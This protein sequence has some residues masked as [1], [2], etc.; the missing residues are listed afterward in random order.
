MLFFMTDRRHFLKHTLLTSAGLLVLPLLSFEEEGK[1]AGEDD[2]LEKGFSSPP[3]S[4]RPLAFWMWMNGH[5]TKE[6]IT[7]DLATMK[8]MGLAGAFV[9]NTGMGIPKGPVAYGS[10]RWLA[11]LLHAMNTARGLG[12]DLYLHNSPGYSSTGG[13]RVTPEISMQQ[14]VWTELLVESRG[15][16]DVNLPQPY[17]K[18]DY[19]KDS[20]LLAFPATA[21]KMRMQDALESVW[22]NGRAIDKNR[23][24]LKS[25]S[26]GVELQPDSRGQ[27]VLQLAFAE[28]FEARAISITRKPRPSA[29]LYEDAYDHPPGIVLQ[30]SSDGLRFETVCAVSMP[31]LRFL[32][33]PGTKTFPPVKAKFF[34][35]VTAQPTMLTGVEL[36]AAPRLNDWAGKANFTDRQTAGNE[37]VVE[38][39]FIIDP[40]TVVDLS[41]QLPANGR[42]SC[43]LPAGR[44]TLLRIGHT[45]T[46]TETIASPEG[47]GG[48]E[49]DKFSRQAVDAYFQLY[50]DRFWQRLK[51]FAANSFKGFLIDSY[52]I[53]RQNWTANFPADFEEITGYPILAWMPA[54]TGRIVQSVN[55]SE[56]FLWDVRSTQA[57]LVAE[58]YYGRFK[59]HCAARGLQFYAQPNGDGVFDS[60]QAGQQLDVPMAEFWAR[61]VPGTL[62]LCKQAVSIAHGYGKKT[63]AAEAFTAMPKLSKW[64]GYPVAFKSQADY[65]Y[66]LGINRL[67]FH[68]M[69]HQPYTTGF[70]GM[71][72]G[73]YGT[74]FDRNNTWTGQ[75][76][77]WVDCLSRTQYLLQQG[78][79]VA[80]ILYFKGEEPES[81]IPDLNYVD[82]P[83]PKSLAG[84]VIGPDVLLRYL[85]IE[86][87]EIVLAGGSRY[88]LMIAA[89]LK[90]LS[91]PLLQRLKELVAQG[92]ILVVTERP[93]AAMGLGKGSDA[94]VKKIAGEVWGEL[95]GKTRKEKAFGNGMLYWNKPFG[96]VLQEQSIAPDFEFTALHNDAAIH[97][98]HRRLG[99]TEIYF[100]SNQ[101]RRSESIVARFRVKGKLPEGWNAETK[102]SGQFLLYAFE[103]EQTLV[104]LELPPSGSLF[105]LFRQRATANA[106]H[107]IWQNGAVLQ[108]TRPF[109]FRRPDPFPDITNHFTLLLW[110]KPDTP[111]DAPK[112][113]LIFPPEG[114][115]V[116]GRGHAACGLSAGQNGVR[117][118][119]RESGSNRS[120]RE[121]IRVEQPLEGWTHLALRYQEG[122]PSLFVNGKLVALAEGSGNM[123]HP[124]LGT[125]PTDEAFSAFFEGDSTA[126][127]LE[128][129]ALSE[130]AIRQHYQKGLPLP[131]G[132]SPIQI[133][134]AKAG[135]LLA[136]VWQNG[137]YTLAGDTTKKELT[138]T[139]CKQE[140][141][142]GPWQVG[143]PP[144]LG[145]PASIRLEKLISLHR[146]PQFGV[147]HFSGKASYQ[148]QFG[149]AKAVEP[150]QR[151][152]LDLGR[153]EVMAEVVLNGKRMG[154]LWKEPFQLDITKALR[155]GH[156][157]LLIVVT[158]LW[159]NRLIGDAQLPEENEYSENGFILRL[160]DWYLQNQPKH[161]RRIGFATWN[162]FRKEDPLL[163]S[164]LLGPVRL[165][166]GVET[167]L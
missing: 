102:E 112:G 24:I 163:E 128:A 54:F 88:R 53:G 43:R 57:T 116:Y 101:L 115:V 72:M 137:D 94:E 144:H 156:N 64:S 59:E 132:P 35:L 95:D 140:V 90:K 32:D 152:L 45:C 21:E 138:I 117:V 33:A 162:P 104:P 2:A 66:A 74:H 153:V 106:A 166:F 103:K 36:T 14:L 4:A 10:E 38:K 160:P 147:K 67:V 9:Y 161:G 68:V 131:A 99:E 110:I 83:V 30:S 60:L 125:P 46:G 158:N 124:G 100:V 135:A 23:L 73:P 16:V 40:A 27:A 127:E 29:N 55:D 148:I 159:P 18:Q 6:G 164:G 105:V 52:E 26:G 31:L 15:Q 87:N 62:N 167:R 75:A 121:V 86:G 78:W 122:K 89:P 109:P 118:Y 34:R 150:Q 47:A 79:P 11:L 84:D 77:E 5:I 42:L 123:V 25:G 98:T 41:A 17:T 81:G 151:V 154:V 56:K 136:T 107:T 69:V 134:R 12:L 119:E 141:L 113:V 129:V 133:R 65:F 50:L 143:F 1:K 82:P 44:W 28:P 51:P 126:P 20:F 145:A 63:V 80:D 48:L 111:S 58:N 39:E 19:Y 37:Q 13:E 108:S 8:Q 93:E 97:Y 3:A 165:F 70:P 142:Q 91:L 85:K 157:E 96:E 146:H 22:V 139:A 155:P 92:M 61:Y 120:A 149:L 76:A 49:I 7:R 114:A 130:E 71:T